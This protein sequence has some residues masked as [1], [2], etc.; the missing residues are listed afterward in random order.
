[1]TERISIEQFK[2]RQKEESL[3]IQVANYL[4]IQYSSVIFRSD[5]AAG[6]KMS[7]GQ[8]MK[9]KRMQCGKSYPDLFIAEP[10]NGYSG[11]FLELKKD[12][13]EV[14]KKDGS[15]RDLPHIQEQQKMLW[16]LQEK[17]YAAVFACGFDDA[18]EFI[19]NYLKQ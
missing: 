13:S 7:I 12:F 9:H 15:L 14:F 19:D 3:Q 8:A 10:R 1:M 6:I 17:G 4:R 11:L 18:K 5:F 2:A 16:R